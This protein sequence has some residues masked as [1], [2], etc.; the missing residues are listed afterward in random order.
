MGVETRE[1]SENKHKILF[2]N[3][4]VVIESTAFDSNVLC[5]CTWQA[6]CCRT[7]AF[8]RLQAPEFSF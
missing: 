7:E 3:V 4:S 6:A 5:S 8:W 1:N 2:R